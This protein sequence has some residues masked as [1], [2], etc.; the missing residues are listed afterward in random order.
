MWDYEEDLYF[1]DGN[2]IVQYVYEE[3]SVTLADTGYN[4]LKSIYYALASLFSGFFFV[5]IKRLRDVKQLN[6]FIHSH[7]L[8]DQAD[9][10]KHKIE[11][12]L[13]KSVELDYKLS[14][15][16][17]INIFNVGRHIK[18]ITS[19]QLQLESLRNSLIRNEFRYDDLSNNSL[20]TKYL[21]NKYEHSIKKSISRRLSDSKEYFEYIFSNN[22]LTQQLFKDKDRGSS[23]T[24]IDFQKSLSSKLSLTISSTFFAAALMIS[25]Y[26]IYET[27]ITNYY[28]VAAQEKL[29][30]KYLNGISHYK[31]NYISEV[32]MSQSVNTVSDERLS[33][34]NSFFEFFVGGNNNE[35]DQSDPEAFAVLKVPSINLKQYVTEGTNTENLQIGPGRYIGSNYP[36]SFN[37]N[38]AIAGHRTTY[39]APFE[40]I[41]NLDMGDEIHLTYNNKNYVYIVDEMHVV[42]VGTGEYYLYNRGQARITLTT[43]HPKYSAKQRLIVTGV[44]KTIEHY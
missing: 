26:S 24:I 2:F 15:Q 18:N 31:E 22:S 14:N 12:L 23:I 4:Y 20:F 40:N 30:S 1:T 28:Q 8:K 32:D 36:D 3:T 37:S 13:N 44:L 34:R 39:G 11:A 17:K 25:T 38:I 7:K 9:S 43:C 27:Y 21:S 35:I 19:T 29:E 16:V 41:D 33:L 42:D 6:K 5:L 10:I